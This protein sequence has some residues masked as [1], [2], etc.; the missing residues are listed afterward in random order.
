MLSG[1]IRDQVDAEADGDKIDAGAILNVWVHVD[2]G[3]GTPAFELW[4]IEF[5]AHVRLH[6]REWI[7]QGRID[8]G[9]G[10]GVY[11]RE[12]QYRTIGDGRTNEQTDATKD[13]A[14]LQ[15]TKR[16][17]KLKYF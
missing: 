2:A 8:V 1:G 11:E 6:H 16:E 14:K 13:A 7:Q 10:W 3:A 9:S 4:W 15:N 17:E 5:S 12:K